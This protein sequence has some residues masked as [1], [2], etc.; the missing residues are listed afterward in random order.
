M[1]ILHNEDHIKTGQYSWHEV[2][3][4]KTKKNDDLFSWDHQNTAAK[5]KANYKI[6]YFYYFVVVMPSPPLLLFHPSDQRRNLLPLA[7]ST[8]SSM[9]W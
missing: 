2:Y 5:V 9:L 4:L 1:F 6:I 3:V 7:Q 8:L